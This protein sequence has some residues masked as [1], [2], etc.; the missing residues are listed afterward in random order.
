MRNYYV[1]DQVKALQEAISHMIKTHGFK[2]VLVFVRTSPS[3]EQTDKE[4]TNTSIE[5]QLEYLRHMLLACEISVHSERAV[6]VSASKRDAVDS[7]ERRLQELG[8][9]TLVMT[10]RVDRMTRSVVQFERLQKI[11]SAGGHGVLSFLW[12]H[13]TE[14]QDVCF[15]LRLP[16]RHN[17]QKAVVNWQAGLAAQKRAPMVRLNRPLHQPILWMFGKDTRHEQSCPRALASLTSPSNP[18]YVRGYRHAENAQQWARAQAT[19]NYQGGPYIEPQLN[20]CGVDQRGINSAM[21][22]KQALF[23]R[24]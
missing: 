2:R 19:I 16:E 7:V 18:N 17:T 22:N 23:I 15:A 3:P 13:E 5:R 14:P 8:D 9:N 12:D 4:D 24:R 11:V 21:T 10:T 1:P 20:K 6:G